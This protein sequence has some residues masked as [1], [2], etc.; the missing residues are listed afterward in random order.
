MEYY[1]LMICSW[2]N[3][4]QLIIIGGSHHFFGIIYYY[5]VGLVIAVGV[6]LFCDE[7][8][9]FFPDFFLI[10]SSSSSIKKVSQSVKKCHKVYQN[11][12]N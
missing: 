10:F 1:C 9:D 2:R 7:I 6:V 5:I 12:V 11:S 4:R 8:C 3:L